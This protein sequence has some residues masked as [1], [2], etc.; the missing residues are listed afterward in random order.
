M[1]RLLTIG[2]ALHG[3]TLAIHAVGSTYW[4][5]RLVSRSADHDEHWQS[6][7]KMWALMSTGILLLMLHMMETLVWALTFYLL[8][9]TQ[10]LK[11]FEEAVYFSLVTFT[12]LGY[13]DIILDEKWRILSGMAALNGMLLVGWSTALLF[14]VV[15]RTWRLSHTPKTPH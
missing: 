6:G 4:M 2:I 11:T 7:R 15:Q 5:D 10:S 12:T 1:L 3:I 14:T 8:P 9:E 13:G